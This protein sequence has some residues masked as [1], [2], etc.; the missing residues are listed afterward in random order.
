MNRLRET[1]QL[2]H[3]SMAGLDFTLG[4]FVPQ[5]SAASYTRS[6]CRLHGWRAYWR[7]PSA[8]G[9]GGSMHATHSACNAS[10]IPGYL[11]MCPGTPAHPV[12]KAC[13]ETMQNTSL[14]H[15][16]RA[17]RKQQRQQHL[18]RVGVRASSERTGGES[19]AASDVTSEGN[20]TR[21]RDRRAVRAASDTVEARSKP[22]TA[23]DALKE[24]SRLRD[25]HLITEDEWAGARQ[26]VLDS[27]VA[28][29]LPPAGG[30]ASA[31][32][33]VGNAARV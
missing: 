33:A 22:K 12:R 1:C 24:L 16:E 32:R 3:A 13:G 5:S 15:H 29:A 9:K 4:R 2:G 27:I 30:A 19:G 26:R 6:S 28:R 11:T 7:P 25:E 17:E 8:V 23:R 14:L 20:T 18:E 21:G 10:L 31:A